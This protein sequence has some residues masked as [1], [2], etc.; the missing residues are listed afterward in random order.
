MRIIVH[1]RD[2][3]M[4]YKNTGMY[5]FCGL[6]VEERAQGNDMTI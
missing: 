1:M 5:R 3:G 2:L 6:S 4:I